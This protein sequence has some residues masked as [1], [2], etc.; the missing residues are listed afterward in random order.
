MRQIYLRKGDQE[1]ESALEIAEDTIEITL[2]YKGRMIAKAA[3]NYFAA[4]CQ[5]RLELEKEEVTLVCN[6]ASKDVYPSA[7][8]LSM[9]AGE[10]AYLL[11]MGSPARSEDI[12]N[13]FDVDRAH[14]IECTVSEQAR[15]L[16]HHLDL[17]Q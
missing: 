5:V 8:M 1:F 11:K 4:L 13:I 16:L 17:Y 12:L 6:G 3:D 15:G 9:G 2:L 7:M 14:F 10:L